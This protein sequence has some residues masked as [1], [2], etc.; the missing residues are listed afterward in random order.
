MHQ[1]E[2]HHPIENEINPNVLRTESKKLNNLFYEKVIECEYES[3]T[4]ATNKGVLTEESK[5]KFFDKVK[6]KL[7]KLKEQ[8]N[9]E[10]FHQGFENNASFTKYLE[11]QEEELK[12]LVSDKILI[13]KYQ[14]KE[15][16]LSEVIRFRINIRNDN[17]ANEI[18]SYNTKLK[19]SRKDKDVI[20]N[21]SGSSNYKKI[22]ECIDLTESECV[23]LKNAIRYLETSLNNIA[24]VDVF[25]RELKALKGVQVGEINSNKLDLHTVVLYKT[26]DA[27]KKKILV[28][29][30]NNPLFSSHLSKFNYDSNTVEVL[31]D[32]N[33]KYKIYT[34]E[35][36][37][38]KTNTAGQ[39]EEPYR[40]CIDI[41]VKISFVLNNSGKK[42]KSVLDI[43]L[44]PEIKLI[45]N[46]PA[47]D[48]LPLLE[49]PVKLKQ[50]SNITKI[51]E[52]NSR[53]KFYSDQ[54][55]AKLD[56]LSEILE[57]R[58]T[59]YEKEYRENILRL[60]DKIGI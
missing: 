15:S 34:H 60:E 57:S 39:I 52:F 24:L 14:Y 38:S 23:V 4:P 26:E 40:D 32:S 43:M 37:N 56:Y 53:L 50:T 7:N 17:I 13:H 31:C 9:E 12:E 51:I 30:P 28:I 41:S 36:G 25:K 33:K 6:K 45:T 42:Y 16:K 54:F 59:I 22:Q 29:D 11:G 3:I 5:K 2:I 18:S 46:N 27:F 20:S 10:D 47:I 21:I 44:S 19:D 1:D 35:G 49:L 8:N 55:K 48:K 58:K